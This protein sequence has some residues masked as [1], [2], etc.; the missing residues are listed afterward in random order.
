[1][2][3]SFSEL[4][5]L[6]VRDS[7]LGLRV[8]LGILLAAN[9]V[10]AWAVFRPV[11]GSAEELDQQ[12]AQMRKQI[13]QKRIAL[14]RTDMISSKMD[15]ARQAGDTFFNS[16]FMSRKAASSTILLE[17]RKAAKDSG[18]KPKGD[19]FT[20][21]PIEGSDLLSMMTI[22]ANYEG[23]YGDLLQF[24]NRLD[25]SQRFLI[26]ENLQAAPQQG[27]GLLNVLI[28]LNTFV[29]EEVTQ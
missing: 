27:S 23:T 12:L 28:R 5:N 7:Q 20:F 8:M 15:Q 17:L 22:S 9:L 26:L 10:A 14:K 21:E 13:Q 24:V 25:K 6:V 19:A 4:K 11:G 1:M 29:R 16:Y 3:R 18:M 2:P